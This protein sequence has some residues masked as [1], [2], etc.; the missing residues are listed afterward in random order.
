MR[1]A[2]GLAR[3]ALGRAWPNPAVGCILAKDDR[4]VGRGWTQPGGRPHA[5]T[6]ALGRAGAAASGAVAYVTLEPCAH[7]GRTPPCADALADA[8]IS[9]AVIAI[10]DPDPRVDGAGAER[11]KRAGIEVAEGA[12]ATEANEVNAGFIRRVRDGRPL[13]TLKLA[14]TLDGRGDFRRA[15][16]EQQEALQDNQRPKRVAVGQAVC[17][18]R[19][20]HD[21]AASDEHRQNGRHQMLA[22]QT[23]PTVLD[24]QR[25]APQGHVEPHLR[26]LLSA[27]LE[28]DRLEIPLLPRE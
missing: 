25:V 2:L 19:P 10:R 3:R 28:E 17:G 7:H 13:V 18:A 5:E 4:V 22:S 16:E 1:A 14:S 6:E 21:E 11:L 26:H 27:D 20:P 23:R 8:G 9:R 12:C 24:Q 15:N